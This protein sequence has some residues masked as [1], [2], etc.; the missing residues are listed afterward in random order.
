MKRRQLIKT[1]VVTALGMDKVGT[2]QDSL[3]QNFAN[4]GKTDGIHPTTNGYRFIA[5]SVYEYLKA[6]HLDGSKSIVCFGDSV[7]GRD[8]FID[9]DRYAVYLS[10]LLS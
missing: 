7:T 5:R 2:E 4:A 1:G 9:K 6:N 3:I 8:G 10:K